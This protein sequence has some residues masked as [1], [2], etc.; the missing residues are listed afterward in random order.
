MQNPPKK[1][2]VVDDE[3]EM[4]LFLQKTLERQGYEVITAR[5]GHEALQYARCLEPD[6]ML[7]DIILPDLEG[8]KISAMLAEHPSTAKIPIIFLTGIITKKGEDFLK[9]I[10]GK[11]D[12]LAKPLNATELFAKVSKILGS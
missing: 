5:N 2:L 1:I 11:Y 8:S 6:L 3:E 9:K 4:V 7:L 10:T 12:V